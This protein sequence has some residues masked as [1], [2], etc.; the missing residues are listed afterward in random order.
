VKITGIVIKGKQQGRKIGFPTVNVEVENKPSSGVYAGEVILDGKNYK[1]AIFIPQKGNY[2]EAH[3]LDFSGDIYGK[4]IEI[5]VGKKIRE[6]K[7]FQNDIE[8]KK[9]IKKDLE[10]SS[11]L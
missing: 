11:I 7:K 6:V 2:I 9:Q 10:A 1:S 3:I 8:L 5:L 4:K